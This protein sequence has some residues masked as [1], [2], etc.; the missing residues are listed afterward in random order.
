MFKRIVTSALIFGAAALA[1][2]VA[3]QELARC[4]PRASMT[5]ALKTRFGESLIGA[6]LQ[7]ATQ[8]LEVWASDESGSFTVLI[9]FADGT[10]CVMTYGRYWFTKPAPDPTGKS[11]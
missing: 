9:S 2:P 5:E 10:S 8:M 4:L 1:P 11:G 6:G 3:A 7:S